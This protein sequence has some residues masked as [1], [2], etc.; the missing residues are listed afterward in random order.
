MINWNYIKKQKNII[1][2]LLFIIIVTFILSCNTYNQTT[3]PIKKTDY[4][5]CVSEYYD[6]ITMKITQIDQ[7]FGNNKF[8]DWQFYY[9]DEWYKGEMWYFI[10][11]FKIKEEENLFY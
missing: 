11:K 1:Y 6:T 7:Y 8:K 2:N 4:V 5:I 9:N 10:N 3:K